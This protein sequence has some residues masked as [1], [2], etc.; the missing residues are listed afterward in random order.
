MQK[1]NFHTHTYLCGHAFGTAEEMI[2]AAIKSDFKT[3]GISEH[4]GHNGWD[5]PKD[6]LNFED[7]DAYLE[8]MY[9]LKEKYKDQINVKVGFECELYEENKDYLLA[10]KNKCD[11]MICGQ[12]TVKM[13][14][15]D[16]FIEPYNSDEH[17]EQMANLV[18][19]GIELGLFK[20]I[21]HPD[22][23][24]MNQSVYTPR[25]KEAIRKIAKCA[26][27]HDVVM[28]INIKGCKYGKRMYDFGESYMY[29]NDET[30]RILG[31]EKV[32]VCFGYDA[33]HPDDLMKK[34]HMEEE[35]KERYKAFNLQ[36]VE[37]LDL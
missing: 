36:Y 14:T 33:H 9:A 34:R 24:M 17:I 1:F 28:E 13:H 37:D 25:K 27:K 21:A 29:P 16:V 7:N 19:E 35:L 32:R 8:M 23:F 20:Y 26:K 3:I 22:Y 4:I 12:H 5:D 31:E 15:P 10:M 18:C 2:L 30:M 6:R 11:Y